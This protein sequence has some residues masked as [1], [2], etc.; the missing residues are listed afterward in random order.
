MDKLNELIKFVTVKQMIYIGII[1]FGLL[2]LYIVLRYLKLKS[3]KRKIEDID[4]KVNGIKSL[5]LQYRLGRVHSISKNMPEVAPKYQEFLEEFQRISNFEKNVLSVKMNEADEKVYYGKT[6]KVGK[7][8]VELY[9]LL[10]QYESDSK[11]LLK[12][13]EEITE[14]EN[15]QRV[16]IIKTKEKYRSAI[17]EFEKI[18]YK[19]EDYIPHIGQYFDEIDDAFVDL[20][21]MMNN[22]KYD[23]AGDM[24]DKIK[25]K[26]EWMSSILKDLANYVV[27]VRKVIPTKISDITKT[28]EH[29]KEEGYS[30][31]KIDVLPK[32][33]LLSEQLEVSTQKVKKLEFANLDEE[34]KVILDDIENLNLKINT[35]VS[36]FQQFKEVWKNAYNFVTQMYSEYKTCMSAYLKM[37]DY[38]VLDKYNIDIEEHFNEF[39]VLVKEMNELE[40]EIKTNDFSYTK[41][42]NKIS[43]LRSQTLAHSTYIKDFNNKKEELYIKQN[44]ANDELEN[45][46][47]A[48]LEIKSQ[49]KNKHLPNISESYKD[50]IANARALSLE[51]QEYKKQKPIDLDV[52]SEKVNEARDIVY[53]LYDNVHNLIITV[54][55]VEE[56]I[57]FGNRY[58]HDFLE[59]NTE[60]TKAEVLFRNGDYT[61]ALSIVVDIIEK[62]KPGSYEELIKKSDKK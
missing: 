7:M 11:S 50:F 27:L 2:M 29:M 23:E 1:L 39:E 54:E 30:I 62:I 32:I 56:A 26:V 40:K 10:D 19:V 37:K 5:P 28:I 52:L 12:K 58:R 34:L 33:K 55:M 43:E 16:E 21:E 57:V 17:D 42:L 53:K 4:Q 14:V 8:I 44:R 49:I 60:L 24:T 47:I 20:E 48:L 6:R 59:V 46:N 18:R 22:Q 25:E 13:M 61:K 9:R 15:I 31:E 41:T 45:V 35:E 36:S 38:F 51:I 3:Y